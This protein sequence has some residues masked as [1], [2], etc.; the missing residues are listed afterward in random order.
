MAKATVDSLLMQGKT[1]FSSRGKVWSTPLAEKEILRFSYVI[2]I[3]ENA[4]PIRYHY[5]AHGSFA[6]AKSMAT[7]MLLNHY[8]K[9]VREAP[10]TGEMRV[11][12]RSIDDIRFPIHYTEICSRDI[13]DNK[14]GIWASE[15]N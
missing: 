11:I 14:L 5:A 10:G 6:L 3:Y 2:E 8:G 7:Q 15:I 12:I 13:I 1:V 9:T 4:L